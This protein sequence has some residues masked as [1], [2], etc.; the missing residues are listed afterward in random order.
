MYVRLIDWCVFLEVVR[1]LLF[2][3]VRL[4]SRLEVKRWRFIAL[5]A[6]DGFLS[7]IVKTPR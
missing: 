3:A 2:I 6:C 4:K 1:V 5:N 7:D